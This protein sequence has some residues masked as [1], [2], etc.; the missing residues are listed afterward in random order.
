MISQINKNIS[1]QS[2]HPADNMAIVFNIKTC[3]Y[4][5]LYLP[6][7]AGNHRY[8]LNIDSVSVIPLPLRT[9]LFFRSCCCGFDPCCF[10][11]FVSA[12]DCRSFLSVMQHVYVYY[13]ADV[14]YRRKILPP[15][16]PSGRKRLKTDMLCHGFHQ[17]TAQSQSCPS[18]QGGK[19]KLTKQANATLVDCLTVGWLWQEWRRQGLPLP[20]CMRSDHLFW[21]WWRRECLLA[22]L[23]RRHTLRVQLL[24]H[25]R[26]DLDCCSVVQSPLCHSLYV[27]YVFRGFSLQLQEMHASNKFDE[28]E[29]H[30]IWWVMFFS[31]SLILCR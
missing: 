15:Q 18:N 23:L 9:H 11:C 24:L 17:I 26:H 19:E 31:L 25:Q 27:L 13:K 20:P 16:G 12:S 8:R 1:F 21:T 2:L 22:L 30:F 5:N 7:E 28:F 10:D 6:W 4:R 29:K 3:I 14:L